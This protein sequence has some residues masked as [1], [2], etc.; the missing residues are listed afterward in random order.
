M[1]ERR[2]AL[3]AAPRPPVFVGRFHASVASCRLVDGRLALEFV[4]GKSPLDGGAGAVGDVV[5]LLHHLVS[6][7]GHDLVF[8]FGLLD[9]LYFE[10]ELMCDLLADVLDLS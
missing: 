5:E 9:V 8:D 7:L 3:L 6:P 4:S 2:A 1:S 10:I